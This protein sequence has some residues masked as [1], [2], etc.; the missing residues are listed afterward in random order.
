[1]FYVVLPPG[2]D[3]R[4]QK[5]E[6]QQEPKVHSTGGEASKARRW[7]QGPEDGGNADS[8]EEEERRREEEDGGREE[9][10]PT[11]RRA[12]V[13]RGWWADEFLS[14]RWCVISAHEHYVIGLLTLLGQFNAMNAFFQVSIP[15]QSSVRSTSKD[16]VRKALSASSRMTLRWALSPVHFCLCT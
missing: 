10:L 8:R 5:Q 9:A 4:S 2:Q 11:G 1:M 14:S 16:C 3:L 6:G 13:R 15:S 12:A 7:S